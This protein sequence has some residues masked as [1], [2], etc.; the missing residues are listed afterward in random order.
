M[1]LHLMFG[2]LSGASGFGPWPSPLVSIYLVFL[3][4]VLLI[5]QLRISRLRTFLANLGISRRGALSMGLVLA[6]LLELASTSLLSL[7]FP[8]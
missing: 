1:A 4:P 2:A 8:A 6:V 3:V 5:F 7:L